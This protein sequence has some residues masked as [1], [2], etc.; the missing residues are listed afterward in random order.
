MCA[1]NN[2]TGLLV[3]PLVILTKTFHILSGIMQNKKSHKQS[4]T[5]RGPRPMDQVGLNTNKEEMMDTEAVKLGV[6]TA[7][8]RTTQGNPVVM[9]SL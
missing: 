8:R 4:S 7:M 3:L 6:I 1:V 9:S 5:I 2:V